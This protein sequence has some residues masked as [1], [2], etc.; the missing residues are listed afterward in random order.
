MRLSGA[1]SEFVR[2]DDVGVRD[3][4]EP[5]TTTIRMTYGDMLCGN[6][7]WMDA[8][9]RRLGLPRRADYAEL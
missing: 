6:P 1:K 3:V 4:E 8:G 5:F 7:V 9:G 2:S